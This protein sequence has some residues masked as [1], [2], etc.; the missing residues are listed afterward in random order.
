MFSDF[1]NPEQLRIVSPGFRKVT[2]QSG[3]DLSFG[4][5]ERKKI[6]LSYT[7][8]RSSPINKVIKGKTNEEANGSVFQ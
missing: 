8:V 3:T 2:V 7:L 4:R 1:Y 5:K 6:L